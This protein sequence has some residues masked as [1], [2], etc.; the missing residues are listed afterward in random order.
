MYQ[1]TLGIKILGQI[2]KRKAHVF[3]IALFLQ[4]FNQMRIQSPVE[5]LRWSFSK[6]C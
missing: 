6:N 2:L 5:H 3:S 4:D 1:N